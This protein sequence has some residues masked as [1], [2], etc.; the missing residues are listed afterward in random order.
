MECRDQ[1]LGVRW[2]KRNNAERKRKYL[3]TGQ[4]KGKG[5]IKRKRNYP[6]KE[7]PISRS[8]TKKREKSAHSWQSMRRLPKNGTNMPR[9]ELNHALP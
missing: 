7:R 2:K 3:L 1:Q 5:V 6:L 9:S 8:V 4:L